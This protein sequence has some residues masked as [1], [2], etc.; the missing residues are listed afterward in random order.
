M[1][2]P[3]TFFVSAVVLVLSPN[4]LPVSSADEAAK[5]AAVKPPVDRFLT[6]AV[7]RAGDGTYLYLTAEDGKV[8]LY[9]GTSSLLDRVPPTGR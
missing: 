6:A 2:Y 8:R 7:A 9:L 1:R 5:H 4:G 3:Y